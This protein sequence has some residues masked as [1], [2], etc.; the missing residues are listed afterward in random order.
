MFHEH[1]K[2]RRKAAHISFMV[3]NGPDTLDVDEIPATLDIV[4]D[5]SQHQRSTTKFTPGLMN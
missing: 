4:L 3:I 2:N 5:H 1:L